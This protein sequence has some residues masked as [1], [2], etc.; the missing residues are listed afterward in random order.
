MFELQLFL[1]L[2]SLLGV[3]CLKLMSTSQPEFTYH[4]EF[5]YKA[6]GCQL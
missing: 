3:E 4:V 1:D 5:L 2:E 6:P